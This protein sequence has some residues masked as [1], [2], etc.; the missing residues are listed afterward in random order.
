M[1]VD[2]EN[3]AF[4][5][6]LITV[7][8]MSFPLWLDAWWSLTVMPRMYVDGVSVSQAPRSIRDL[9]EIYPRSIRDLSEI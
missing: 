3:W 4:R 6:R 7:H 2:E 8:L 9:S 1:H 5:F